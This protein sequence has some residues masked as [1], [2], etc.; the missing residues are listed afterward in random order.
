M[1]S[2]S[3]LRTPRKGTAESSVRMMVSKGYNVIDI[4]AKTLLKFRRTNVDRL[5]DYIAKWSKAFGVQEKI[6]QG[7]RLREATEARLRRRGETRNIER[8]TVHTE[9]YSFKQ[10]QWVDDSWFV[11]LPKGV[12]GKQRREYAIL[13]LMSRMSEQYADAIKTQADFAKFVTSVEIE[14]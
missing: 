14:D 6:V 2:S 3:G 5:T 1:S 4:V 7:P 10:D 12:T 11:D 9:R 8:I 13:A